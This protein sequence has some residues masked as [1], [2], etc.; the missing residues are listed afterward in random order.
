MFQSYR[1]QFK[2]LLAAS[3]QHLSFVH[4]FTVVDLDRWP[5]R[6][7]RDRSLNRIA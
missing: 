2:L 5:G 6:E 7:S 3:M 4:V 1:M